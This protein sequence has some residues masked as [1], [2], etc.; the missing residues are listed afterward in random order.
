MT[1]AP[2]APAQASATAV[3]PDARIVRQRCVLVLPSTGAFDSRTYRIASTLAGRGHEVTVV[4]RIGPG[5]EDEERHAAGYRILRVPVSAADGLPR[6]LRWIVGRIRRRPAE[7]SLAGARLVAP[8]LADGSRADGSRADGSRADGSLAG[9]TSAA[10]GSVARS[11]ST[12]PV[13][14]VRGLAARAARLLG[15]VRRLAAIALTVRSQSRRTRAV[16]PA[17]DLVHAMAYMGIPIGLRL[18]RRDRAAVIYDA[19]DIYVD[20]ANLARLPGPARSLFGRIERRWAQQASRVVTV[21]EPYAAVMAERFRVPS[22]LVVL[23]CSYRQDAVTPR[24]RRFHDVLGLADGAQVVL[25][26][27]GLS[28]DRGIEQLI[29]A[30]AGLPA[31]AHLVLLGYGV[32][33]AGLRSTASE[34][35]FRGRLHV[36]PAVPP[37]ELLDWVGSADVVAMPIQPST[38]NHRLTTPNKLFEAMAAGVPLVASD[39]PGMAPIVRATGCG[40]VVDPT[41]PSAIGAAITTIL[42]M[43]PDERL[44]MGGRGRDAHLETY[45]WESQAALLLAEYGRLT[46]RPW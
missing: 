26:H 25:Y 20:A 33:E 39:L 36:L 1:T 32:L 35:R 23:N 30:L 14:G 15:S 40:L 5:L 46:G 7:A 4:A 10:S 9:A 6:P 24:P 45:N 8:S 37:T 34:S 2:P 19:R 42:E 38:L 3:A 18:G 43:T 41:D 31:R 16:A 22:P 29:D 27:G 17:A 13:G 21:N 12:R 11:A 28:R 44:A